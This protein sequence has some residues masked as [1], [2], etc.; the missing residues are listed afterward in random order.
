MYRQSWTPLIPITIIIIYHW[1]ALIV[2]EVPTNTPPYPAAH[3]LSRVR[4]K[5][6]LFAP[7]PLHL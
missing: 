7:L 3:H 6:G 1:I 2:T 5:H 4:G